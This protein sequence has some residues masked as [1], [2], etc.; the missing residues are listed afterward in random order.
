MF[1]LFLINVGIQSI[2]IIK[3]VA[4]ILAP[5]FGVFSQILTNILG[6]LIGSLSVILHF[7]L[8]IAVMLAIPLAIFAVIYFLGESDEEPTFQNFLDLILS[9]IN[10]IDKI[11]N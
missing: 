4:S 8:A 1:G 11:V 3:S 5:I 10:S 9:W 7:I 6:S 2:D